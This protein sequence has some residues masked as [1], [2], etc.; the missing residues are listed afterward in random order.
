MVKRRWPEQWEAEGV[1]KS[2]QAG[3]GGGGESVHSSRRGGGEERKGSQGSRRLTHLVC[4][5]PPKH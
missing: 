4:R 3:V 2:A 1:G 5:I